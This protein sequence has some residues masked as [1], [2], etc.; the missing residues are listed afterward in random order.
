MNITKKTMT[1]AVISLH[2]GNFP[3]LSNR[4]NSIHGIP[5]LLQSVQNFIIILGQFDY[6]DRK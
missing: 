4:F 5:L 1:R 3:E 6:V 2:L